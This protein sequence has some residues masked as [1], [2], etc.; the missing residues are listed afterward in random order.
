MKNLLTAVMMLIVSFGFVAMTMAEAPGKVK[1]NKMK[2]E[3]TAVDA[4]AKTLKVK[5]KNNQ[6]VTLMVTDKTKIKHGKERKN[7]SDIVAG[8]KV[9]ATYV[10]EGGNMNARD[11]KIAGKKKHK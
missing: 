10:D 11:I 1:M 5:G 7:L 8:T 6:E 9:S 2:G 4:E 3:V